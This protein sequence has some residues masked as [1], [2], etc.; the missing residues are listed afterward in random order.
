METTGKIKV[1]LNPNAGRGAGHRL[2]P[3]IRQALAAHNVAYDLAH[4]TGTNHAIE[5]A[6]QA[7]LD[8]FDLVV[9]AGGDGTISEVVNGLALAAGADG[10]VGTLGMIPVGTGNDFA[11][12][13]GISRN[14]DTAV[15]I[16]MAGR[17]QLVDLGQI[18]IQGD[19]KD[20]LRTFNNN[21]GCGFEAQVTVES[22]KIKRLRGLAVYLTAIFKALISYPLPHI[23][24]T[25]TDESGQP[26]QVSKEMLMISIGNS[27]RT[28]GGF[29]VTPDAVMDDGLYDMALANA[30]S[31]GRIMVLLPKVMMGT[32]TGDAALTFVRATQ[33]RIASPS[34]LPV[35]ADGEMI[36]YNADILDITLQPKRLEVL[37]PGFLKG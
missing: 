2:E 14:L 3:Q 16:I 27:R 9:A 19:G 12:M 15:G 35:H 34:A 29:Y 1:I 23:D 24:V 26:H 31:R 22:R 33:I 17:T 13:A 30:L 37:T 5:L 8:G 32:H 11:D 25:W 10:P 36:S 6:R 20:E 28:G 21:L 18:R 7:K 4:T